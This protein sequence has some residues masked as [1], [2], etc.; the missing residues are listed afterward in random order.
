MI[1]LLLQKEM[2]LSP[3]YKRNKVEQT[4]AANTHPRARQMLIP[5]RGHL[6]R[7]RPGAADERRSVKN[8]SF[9]IY[10]L[11]V[12]L[13]SI[14]CGFICGMTFFVVNIHLAGSSPI[15]DGFLILYSVGCGLFGAMTA[16]WATAAVIS[17]KNKKIMAFTGS[18]AILLGIA[19]LS[20]FI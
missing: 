10:L 11:K 5:L 2:R 9:P 3:Y 1:L 18:V 16:G 17:R 14:A 15:G 4:R 8:M 20:F 13:F 7:P 6:S 19:T 12:L